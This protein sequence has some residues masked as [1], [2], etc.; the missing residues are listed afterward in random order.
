MGRHAPVETKVTVA[1]VTSYVTSAFMLVGLAVLD[2]GRLVEM[3][4]D[5]LSP[6]VMA[7]APALLT[8]RAGW[9]AR[10]TPRLVG[11]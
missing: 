11:R 3:L 4:P 1:A 8:F 9:Q 10:H 5:W 7:V 6:F 2:D